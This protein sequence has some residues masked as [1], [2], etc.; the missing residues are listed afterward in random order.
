MTNP[1]LATDRVRARD[2]GLSFGYFDPGEL[3]A[4]TDVPGVR[5][6]H[7]TVWFGEPSDPRGAGPARTGVT[8]IWPVAQ[9][10]EGGIPAGCAIINGAGEMTGLE[11]AAELGRINTPIVLTNTMG[12]GMAYHATCSYL[13]D[14]DP[15]IVIDRDVRIPIIG[16]CNDA[17]LN[18]VLGLHVKAGH[19]HAALES[20][21]SGPVAEG[22]VGAGTGMRCFQYKGGIGTSSRVLPEKFGGYTVG[23][24]VLANY[25]LRRF[26]TMDGL[27]IGRWLEVSEN[28]SMPADPGSCI[29][30]VGT[31]APLTSGQLNRVAKRAGLG[32]ARTGSYAGNG[33][34]EIVLSF[35]TAYGF[36]TEGSTYVVELL[37]DALIDPLFAATVE[38]TEE[39][40]MNAL[41]MATTTV[42]VDGNVAEALPL[43]RVRRLIDQTTPRP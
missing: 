4:I 41:C 40:V 42:G 2:L 19:V 35:S 5:V 25:G 21:T 38:A 32:L 33:S 26:L 13:I 17:Y 7:E 14:N 36:P 43:D 12:V 34:G 22:A 30:I 16:E 3:N 1:N 9:M 24:L 10:G 6:G 28:R 11:E 39:A 8:A 20:A 29:V 37:R 18:D 31:N 27:P 23:V 15:Q